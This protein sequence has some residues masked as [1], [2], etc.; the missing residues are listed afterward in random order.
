MDSCK[1]AAAFYHSAVCTET[2]N[3]VRAGHGT[4]VAAD[5]VGI[6]YD[7]KVCKGILFKTC[8]WAGGNAGS[9]LTVQAADGIVTENRPL[10]TDSLG[11]K[12]TAEGNNA[13]LNGEV[14]LIHAGN[15]T[16]TAGDALGGIKVDRIAFHIRHAFFLIVQRAA[17]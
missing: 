3:A 6:I 12:Y 16:G 17:L 5:A 4:A 2:G 7:S 15:G 8:T 9:I 13:V 14:V 11:I 10:G 1:A